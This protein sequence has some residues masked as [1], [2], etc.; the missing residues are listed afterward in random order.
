M[1]TR[2]P[3]GFVPLVAAVEPKA[4]RGSTATD[5]PKP[6]TVEPSAKAARAGSE[7][8]AQ[9]EARRA[10][11]KA[12]AEALRAQSEMDVKTHEATGTLVIQTLAGDTGELRHQFPNNATL[13]S[14]AIARYEAVQGA[15]AIRRT[16]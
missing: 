12:T 11:Q 5:L 15:P 14:R 9:D 2:A 13:K 4:K 7:Q 16:V 3:Q 8:I 10:K 6:K 1:D